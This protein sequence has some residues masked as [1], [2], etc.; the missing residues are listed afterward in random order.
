MRDADNAER[1]LALAQARRS[2]YE[3]LSGF[4][5]DLPDPEMVNNLFDPDFDRRLS[6]VASVFETGEIREG[7]RFI[8][9]F[10]SSFKNDSREEILKRM[11]IDRTRLFRGVS[12]EHSPPPPYESFYREQ[13]LSGQTSADVYRFYC[14]LG[15]TLPE[16]WTESPDYLGVEIDFMRLLCQGEEEAWLNNQPEKALELLRASGDFL[17]DH[18]LKWAPSFFE[19]MVEMAGLDFYRGLA[20]LTNGFLKV[21]LRLVEEQLEAVQ[22]P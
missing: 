17:R 18:L 8:S 6:A 4:F 22:R 9:A 13:R 10:I 5:L 3:M 11:A 21:D 20:R 12:E 19:K 14:R 1:H 16:G 15:V 7:L 2:V